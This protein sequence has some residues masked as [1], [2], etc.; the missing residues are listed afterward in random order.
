LSTTSAQSAAEAE[1]RARSGLLVGLFCY[2]IWGFLPLV[3]DLLKDVGS[4]SI[5]AN[6]TVWSLL[7]VGAILIASRRMGEVRVALRDP[8]T[9]RS[10]LISSVLLAANWL[11]YVWA[12]DTGQV[13]EGSFGY[14]INPMVNVGIGM[15]LLGE[16]QNPWQLVSIAVALV[17]IGIQWV[18]IGRIPF[19]ALGLA[20][21]FGFYG[22]FRKTAKVASASGL[23]VET[24]ILIPLAVAWLIYT[25]VQQGGLGQMGVPLNA[26]LLVLTGPV[27]AV[28]LLLFAF[29]VQRLRLTTIGMLQ[30]IGP[31]I[32]FLLA[33]FVLH[34][35]I[36]GL[37]LLSFALIWVSLIIYSADSLWRRGRTAPAAA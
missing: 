22:F 32:Q 35:T 28:P 5:V 20:L 36:N 24:L 10:M 4:V 8:R 14:F 25:V 3:F 1:S 2:F 19:V 37:Q 17:A 34:E 11:I 9:L 31:T 27:T 26:G 18:G 15:L 7:F 33:I 21:S 13:L 23:F 6:R 12:V 30:Y 16:R 29:A